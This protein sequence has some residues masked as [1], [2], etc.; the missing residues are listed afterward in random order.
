MAQQLGNVHAVIGVLS[1]AC[2]AC[3]VLIGVSAAFQPVHGYARALDH[4]AFYALQLAVS[5]AGVVVVAAVPRT[6]CVV[7]VVYCVVLMACFFVGTISFWRVNHLREVSRNRCA[8]AGVDCTPLLHEYDHGFATTLVL[9]LIQVWAI[10][11]M[12]SLAIASTGGR[13][14]T[15]D[16]IAALLKRL[17]RGRSQVVRF[18]GE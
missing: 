7:R 15:T 3:V 13:R 1:V 12:V 8:F 18:S 6:R 4:W 10:H 16:D 9:P 17:R 2:V 14:L 11:P 5:A